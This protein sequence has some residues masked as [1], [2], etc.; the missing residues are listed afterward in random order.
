MRNSGAETESTS[1]FL[2]CMFFANERQKL[3]YDVYQIDAS[4][5]NFNEESLIDV[6]LKDSDRNHVSKKITN[7]FP[8]NMSY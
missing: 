7:I 8:Y 5:K 1:T 3:H 4:I 6:L 2:R